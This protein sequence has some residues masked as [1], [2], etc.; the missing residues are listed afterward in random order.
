MDNETD[1]SKRGAQKINARTEPRVGRGSGPGAA[2]RRRAIGSVLV[3]LCSASFAQDVPT[4]EV[5]TIEHLEDAPP[6]GHMVVPGVTLAGYVTAQFLSPDGP[7]PLP[8]APSGPGENARFDDPQYTRRPRLDLSHLSGIGWWEPTPDWK[9]LG[10]VDFQDVVQFPTHSDAQDGTNSAPYVALERLYADYRLS[11]SL[12]VRAGKFLT[13][14]GRWNQEH[15]DPQ[16]WTV[17]RPLIS[18]SAFPINATGLMVLGSLPVA[19][20]WLDYQVYASDG[21]DWRSSPHTHHFDHGF[22][23]RISSDL[24]ANLQFGVSASRF[25]QDDYAPAEFDL[26]GIDGKWTWGR[27]E[28]SGEAIARN[29]TTV[30]EGE[31]RGGFLQAVVQLTDHW[32][33]VGRVEAYKRAVDSSANRTALVGIVYRSGRHWVFK[34]EWAQPSDNSVGLPSG[35]LSSITLVY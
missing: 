23:G 8:G 35:L 11:D 19:S 2:A 18:E 33:G 13:P 9:V 5:P 20:H 30:T 26:F 7:G 15:S 24:N 29:D 4:P 28:L 10:E 32:W 6:A 34:A 12:T 25:V 3:A 14:I 16:T 1:M 22:G 27:L 31:E 17:L 21:G